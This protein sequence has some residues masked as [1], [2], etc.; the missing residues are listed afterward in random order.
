MTE[1][2]E[3]TAEPSRYRPV[4][5]RGLA[6]AS[7]LQ[8]CWAQRRPGRT[9]AEPCRLFVE[10]L[11]VSHLD[12]IGG[13]SREWRL[14]LPGAEWPMTTSEKSEAGAEGG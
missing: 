6:T 14:G 10:V 12:A 7:Y 8:R 1:M 9:S 13:T 3:V 11:L 5:G 4:S 2:S